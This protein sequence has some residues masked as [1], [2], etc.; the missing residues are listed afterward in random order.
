MHSPNPTFALPAARSMVALVAVLKRIRQWTPISGLI[1]LGCGC[2][3]HCTALRDAAALSDLSADTLSLM[4]TSRHLRFLRHS[5]EAASS[6]WSP[7]VP[8][9]L[10]VTSLRLLFSFGRPVF[11]FLFCLLFDCVVATLQLLSLCE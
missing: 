4:H 11:L 6:Q 7:F 2:A 10:S 1:S 3:V 9:V 8:F 5:N